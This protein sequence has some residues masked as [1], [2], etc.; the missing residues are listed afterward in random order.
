MLCFSGFLHTT[1]YLWLL[2]RQT[3]AGKLFYLSK[4]K[5]I[6]SFW[7]LLCEV[8]VFLVSSSLSFISAK[9]L[10]NSTR[11]HFTGSQLNVFLRCMFVFLV[12]YNAYLVVFY[13]HCIWNSKNMDMFLRKHFENNF[14]MV[15]LKCII[16]SLWALEEVISTENSIFTAGIGNIILKFNKLRILI[17]IFLQNQVKVEFPTK[18][19]ISSKKL[20]CKL[21]IIGKLKNVW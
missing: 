20:K 18:L 10:G 3:F 4:L 7:R 8:Y 9:F 14:I 13:C 17:E 16:G 19:K 15:P 11:T 1:I 12:L 5:N 2:P 21:N 6:L